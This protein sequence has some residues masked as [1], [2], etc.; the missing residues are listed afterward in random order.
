MFAETSSNILLVVLGIGLL[1]FIHELGHFL[2]AKKL[3]VRVFIFSLGFGPPLFKRKFGE[4]EYRL[5]MIPLGGYVKLAGETPSEKGVGASWELMSKSA[6]QRAMVFAAGVALNAVLAFIAFI[7]AFRIGVPFE[8]AEIGAVSPG[9][10]AWEAG[11]KAGDKI[12]KIGNTTDPDFEDVHTTIALS[13]AP[14]GIPLKID[15]SGESLDVVVYPEY[16]ERIGYKIIGI[17]PALSLIVDKIYAYKNG[18]SPAQEAGIQVGD[19]IIAVNGER[20]SMAEEFLEVEATHAGEELILTVLRDDKPI[21][22]KV[23]PVPTQWKLGLSCAIPKIDGIKKDSIAHAIGLQSNDEI[24]GVDNKSITGWSELKNRIVDASE[25]TII[26]SIER[27]S[28]VKTFELPIKDAEAK[29]NFLGG[30]FPL[31]GLTVDMVVEGFP[32]SEIGLMPGDRLVSISGR[33]L[34]GWEDLLYAVR[35]G[36]GKEM[37]IVWERGTETIAKRVTP[38]KAEG[39][40][41]VVFR[42]KKITKQYGFLGACQV[43]SVKAIVNVKMIYLSVKGLL[44]KQVSSKTIG[45][46]ILIAQASYESAKLGIG[47]LIYFIGILSLNLAILNILPIPVL[48]GGHLLFLGIEKLKGSPVSERTFTIAHYIGFALIISLVIYATRNDIMRILEIFK[49]RG[50]L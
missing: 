8:T 31:L 14:N 43:G 17:Q 20:I 29:E 36:E 30:I 33:K 37:E 46:I 28:Q 13:N 50:A 6:G 2:M 24:V 45:G 25:K 22:L 44:T 3:G 26:L 49:Y 23:T 16:S 12:V 7:V 9:K 11:L 39:S 19:T 32:A 34:E 40:T 27:N 10:P 38:R 42:E 35:G 1:I 41:G 21:D 18:R 5:S 4:T 48:D 47:K 15:R